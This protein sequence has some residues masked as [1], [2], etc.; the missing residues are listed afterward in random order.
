MAGSFN[1]GRALSGWWWLLERDSARLLPIGAIWIGA[2][3]LSGGIDY[4]M[5]FTQGIGLLS[6][7]YLVELFF[8]AIACGLALDDYGSGINRAAGEASRRYLAVLGA[9]I[10]S[11]IGIALG[12][13]L[14]ILPGLALA[15]FWCVWLPVLIAERKSPIDALKTSF[16]Y[17]RGDFWAVCGLLALYTFGV[18]ILMFV[19][20][21]LNLGSVAGEPG[22]GLAVDSVLAVLLSLLGTYL[23]VAIY[24]ELTVSNGPDVTA[25]D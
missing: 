8:L 14:L 9:Y 11:I 5:G 20:L 7:S 2:S 10:L 6:T 23:N 3:F 17:V 21:T 19:A 22:L 25:F 15:V 12:V 18:V 1:F 4:A 16:E 24:R 13:L